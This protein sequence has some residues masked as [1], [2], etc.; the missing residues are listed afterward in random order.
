[1][2]GWHLSAERCL[3][4][5][6]MIMP[7]TFLLNDV[8]AGLLNTQLDEFSV[9]GWQLLTGAFLGAWAGPPPAP[10]VEQLRAQHEANKRK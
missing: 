9:P 3:G 7:L 4:R 8:C 6:N 2:P 5:P 1:M 10:P